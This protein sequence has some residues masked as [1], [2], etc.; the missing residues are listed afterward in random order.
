M[1]IA[2]SVHIKR[3]VF[4]PSRLSPCPRP[5]AQ[6]KPSETQR[7]PN[8]RIRRKVVVSASLLDHCF[9]YSDSLTAKAGHG[10]VTM[11]AV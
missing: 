6:G 3:V 2:L 7:A 9:Y 10:S 11:L 4:T 8:R 1:H 5:S